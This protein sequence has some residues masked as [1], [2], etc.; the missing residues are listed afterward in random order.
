M[1]LDD[2]ILHVI[3]TF[4]LPSRVGSGQML[5]LIGGLRW[6]ETCLHEIVGNGN[7]RKLRAGRNLLRLRKKI[8]ANRGVSVDL[9]DSVWRVVVHDWL[10]QSARALRDLCSGE[11]R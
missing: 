4:L 2:A 9:L 1:K 3:A 7:T 5:R 8:I 10:W 11:K 6:L